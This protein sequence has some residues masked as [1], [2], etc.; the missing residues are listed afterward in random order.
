MADLAEKEFLRIEDMLVKMGGIT[1]KQFWRLRKKGAVP[2]PVIESPATWRL[3]DIDAFYDSKA[4]A[5]L[6]KAL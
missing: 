5:K 6:S 3:K 4:S 2:E 1:R